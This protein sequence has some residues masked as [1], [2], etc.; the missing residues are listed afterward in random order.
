MAPYQYLHWDA[1]WCVLSNIKCHNLLNDAA[2]AP[3]G[4][5]K[6]ICDIFQIGL[7]FFCVDS[8]SI[9]VH[10]Q[11]AVNWYAGTGYWAEEWQYSEGNLYLPSFSILG[12]TKAA[13]P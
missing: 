13:I 6:S 4:E 3:V 1:N 9:Y 7:V 8:G 2:W 5:E 11:W 12:S 10:S